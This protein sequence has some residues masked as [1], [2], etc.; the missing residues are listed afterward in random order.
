MRI[1]IVGLG[2]T[3]QELAKEF[4]DAGH[5]IIVIDTQ[6]EL[7]EEFTNN[8]DA[9][10][11]V[12]SGASKEIQL[13]AKANNADVLIA[14]SPMDE[15]NL[16]SCITAKILGTKYTI[17]RVTAEEYVYDENI[18]YVGHTYGSVDEKR[19]QDVYE[20]LLRLKEV[21]NK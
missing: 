2:Q 7:V 18:H 4:I 3:G 6:K 12:G 17:A 5:E 8:Y 21:L 15:V 16:M 1:V 20:N 11:I 13:K 14:L 19:K 10:G 9:V